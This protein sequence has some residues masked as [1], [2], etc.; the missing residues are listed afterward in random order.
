MAQE[1]VVVS[2]DQSA[3]VPACLWARELA[4]LSAGRLA[5]AFEST[6]EQVSMLVCLLEQSQD[7]LS[8]YT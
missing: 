2:V 8:A 5:Q 7:F 6:L 3:K 1:L 4:F